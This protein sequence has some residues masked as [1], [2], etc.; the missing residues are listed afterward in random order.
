MSEDIL[1]CWKCGY[2]LLKYQLMKTK[3]ICPK[4]KKTVLVKEFSLSGIDP[5]LILPGERYQDAVTRLT[6]GV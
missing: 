2:K 3:G 5:K 4:D 1:R 6:A